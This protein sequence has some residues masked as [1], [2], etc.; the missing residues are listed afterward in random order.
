[1]EETQE[2][3]AYE[4][5]AREIVLDTIK[6]A[7][8]IDENA[9][10]FYEA[11][12]NSVNTASQEPNP[13]IIVQDYGTEPPEK[14]LSLKMFNDFKDKSI[15]LQVHKYDS[16]NE[17]DDSLKNYLFN[18]TDLVL[19]DWK[20]KGIHD[21]G[22]TSLKF[23]ADIVDRPNIHFCA[24][25][26]SA[27]Q[28][29]GIPS[30]YKNILSYFS[31]LKSEDYSSFE[32][33]FENVEILKRLKGSL[34][35]IN[36]Y[37]N[38]RRKYGPTLGRIMSQ[39][40][41]LVDELKADLKIEDAKKALIHASIAL[42]NTIKSEENQKFIPTYAS[43]DE[44]I[45]VI[46]NT[47]I[48]ILN[49]AQHSPDEL[50]ETISTQILR[51]EDASYS[52]LLGL[53][54]QSIF[55][56]EC[57]LFNDNES[58]LSKKAL[59][60]Y[61]Q[62]HEKEF[63]SF[64]FDIQM[65]KLRINLREKSLKLLSLEVPQKSTEEELSQEMLKMNVFCNSLKS[66]GDINLNFG[67]VFKDIRNSEYYLCISPLC[68]CLRPEKI[69]NSFWFAKGTPIAETTAIKLG[70]TAF[71]SFLDK[72]TCVKWTE[73]NSH[74]DSDELYKYSPVYIKP[75]QFTVAQPNF[76]CSN[77]IVFKHLTD[78]ADI[79]EKTVKYVTTL[80]V[81]YAQRIANHAFAYPI[82]VGVDFV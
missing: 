79:A 76:S 80:R 10:D 20:L 68:D 64:I 46:N 77:S 75:I 69:N 24:I 36:Y 27:S 51:N 61:Q 67:D 81:N 4:T 22:E 50:I 2:T 42:G 30:I 32:E 8:Y 38:D 52:S 33:H 60:W 56:K 17:S 55:N 54:M 39:Y 29:E 15:F 14:E 65:E 23:L 21:E 48:M 62:K 31:G 6:S 41:D 1:M 73:V 78:Q 49:K 82:R 58:T 53:E 16:G 25:Y 37:R 47:I 57:W 7:V 63:S 74:I 45:V 12:R 28:N 26:T 5:I 59:L 66:T 44:S 40:K 9:Y 19:L 70:D 35:D 11:A 3:Q 13:S 34:D 71:I 72:T 43:L 18:N